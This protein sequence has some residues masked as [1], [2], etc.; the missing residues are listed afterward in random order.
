MTNDGNGATY[1]AWMRADFDWRPAYAWHRRHLALLSGDIIRWVLKAPA[2]M[3]GIDALHKTYPDA[4]FI[5]LHRNPL[6][7]I[8]SMASL[9]LTLRRLTS[10]KHDLTEIG[11]DVDALWRKGLNTFMRARDAEP[12]LADRILDVP[13][14]DLVRAPQD[15]L[16]RIC[17]FIGVPWQDEFSAAVTRHLEANPKDRH[18]AHR[19]TLEQFGL[20]PG[21]LREAYNPYV[22]RFVERGQA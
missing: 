4:R 12:G 1:D 2:H 18:G 22:A 19:Y 14:L 16:R 11:H 8:P 7:V 17:A 5:A 15:A 20:E 13:Y 21:A 10:R 9:T 3:L 6:E